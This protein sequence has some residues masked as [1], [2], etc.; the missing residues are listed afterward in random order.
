MK[1]TLWEGGV[2]GAA[3]LWSPLINKPKRISKQL[4]HITDWLP[5]LYS[6]AGK[7]IKTTDAHN[8]LIGLV[9]SAFGKPGSVFKEHNGL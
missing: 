8:R 3:F 9:N 5:T 4:M 2:H 7:S 1:H 6:A